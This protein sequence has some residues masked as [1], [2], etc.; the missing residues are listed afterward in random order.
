M[1]LWFSGAE[2]INWWVRGVGKAGHTSDAGKLA[3]GNVL[4]I[5]FRDAVFGDGGYVHRLRS[6]ILESGI[7]YCDRTRCVWGAF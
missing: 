3:I 1:H 7:T 4:K 2:I 5:S 6:M